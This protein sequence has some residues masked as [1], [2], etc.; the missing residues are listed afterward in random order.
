MKKIKKYLIIVGCLTALLSGCGKAQDYYNDGVEYAENGKYKD[1]LK[2]FQNAIKENDERAEY[3]I[4][5]GLALNKLNRYEEAKKEFEKALQDTNNKISKENNKQL[6]YGIAMADYGMGEYES[7]KKYCDKALEIEYF[8]EL[9][10]DIRFTKII[11]LEMLG[12]WESAK[13]ECA[14]LIDG[15]E[16]YM[17]AYME[18]AKIERELGNADKVR[19]AYL[20]AIETDK[21]YYEAHFGLYDQYLTEGESEL[22]NEMLEQLISIRSNKAKN[23]VIIGRAYFYQN[24]YEKAREYLQ[25]AYDANNKDSLYY[26]GIVELSQKA[27]Q[28]AADNFNKYIKEKKENLNIEV[29]HQ[30]AQVY[31][32][33]AEYDKAQEMITTG[34]S[35]GSTNAVKNLK[36]SQIILLEKQ[37][38]YKKAKT[39]AKKYIKCYPTDSEMRK[40]LE[41]IN[42]RIK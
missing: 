6:Y 8:E 20:S 39:A 34:L 9:D 27:Y 2:C 25:M 4:G 18:M 14:T 1:A 12:E 38:K 30:L 10:A 29:Y 22:A 33:L 41:F 17:D 15:N 32:A 5:S 19:E 35:Y 3:Y 11:A 16:K 42:T 7:V 28:D 31:T 26:L 23:L 36:K 24:N 21:T 37:G 13:E 40:E